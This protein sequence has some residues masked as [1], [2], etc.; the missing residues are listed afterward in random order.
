MSDDIIEGVLFGIERRTMSP[1]QAVPRTP[2]VL[3]VVAALPKAC[4]SS[5]QSATTAGGLGSQGHGWRAPPL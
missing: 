1:R 3:L 4:R 2:S 5:R